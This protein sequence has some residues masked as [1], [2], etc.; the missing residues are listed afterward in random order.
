MID[1]LKN[2]LRQPGERGAAILGRERHSIEAFYLGHFPHRLF[3]VLH[4]PERAADTGL[5]FCPPFGEE[6]AATYERFA[7][8][9][10]GLA[11]VG[12]AVLRYHPFGTGE[13]DGGFSDFTLRSAFAD[14]TA[15]VECLRER[16]RVKRVGIFGLRFGGSVAVYA[17]GEVRPDFLLLWSPVTNLRHYV[18]ELLRLRLTHELVR[19]GS[20]RPAVTTQEMIQGLEAGQSVDVLGYEL[21]PELYRQMVAS[22]PWPDK[23]CVPELF[24]LARP[25]EKGQTL[26]IVE[27]W[28]SHDAQI[29]FKFVPERAFW[30]DYSS[31]LPKQFATSSCKWLGL[32]AV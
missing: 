6:M 2:K 32:E 20:N 14:V 26:P 8:W 18:H 29:N 7:R 22:P 16:T 9:A 31:A 23:P 24:W 3:A 12:F 30:Q 10:K 17:G 28:R 27:A 5:V 21:S 1:L 19:R 25:A 11:E 15:A 13:S 4:L